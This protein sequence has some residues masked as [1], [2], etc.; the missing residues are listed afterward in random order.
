MKYAVEMGS[1]ATIYIP[2]FI[3]IGSGFR[4]MKGEINTQ[5]RRHRGSN[6]TLQA[7]FHFFGRKYFT[8]RGYAARMVS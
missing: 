2:S 6:M 8:K 1:V 5:T 7:Y 4:N 3:N